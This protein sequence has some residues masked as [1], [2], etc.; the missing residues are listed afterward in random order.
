MTRAVS[1]LRFGDDRGAATVWMLLVIPVVL[2]AIGLVLDAG[3]AIRDWN[4]AHAQ[5]AAAART[6]AAQID[7]AAYR[8]GQPLRLDPTAAR[9]AATQY[10]RASHLDGTVTVAANRVTVTVTR[11]TRT[12]LLGLIGIRALTETAT[13]VAT[14]LHGVTGPAT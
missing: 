7:L 10:L 13:V 3:L 5:A 14:P 9:A 1:R 11:R 4:I 12:Q 6:G 2:A 8:A